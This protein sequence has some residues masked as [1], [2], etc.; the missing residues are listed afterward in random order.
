MLMLAGL[1]AC[2][3]Q[4]TPPIADSACLAF[5]RISYAIPPVQPDGTRNVTSDDGNQL[6]TTKTVEAVQDHNARFGA[7][8][9]ARPPAR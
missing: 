9:K 2:A 1:T 4:G 5:S 7:V 3:T 8:C 6:D